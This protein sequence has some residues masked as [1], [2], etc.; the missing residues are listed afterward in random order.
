MLIGAS[1][2]PRLN[3]SSSSDDEDEDEASQ[4]PAATTS[5]ASKSATA[6]AASAFEDFGRLLVACTVNDEVHNYRPTVT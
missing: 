1:L 3:S 4:A 2:Q 6:T 5:R